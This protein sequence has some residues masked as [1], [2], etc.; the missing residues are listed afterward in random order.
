MEWRGTVEAGPGDRGRKLRYEGDPGMWVPALLYEP[1]A[2]RGRVPAV[3]NPN[4]HHPGGKA[5]DYKQARCINLA[6]RGML[7][8]NTEFIGMGELRA[9]AEH[10]R[11]ALLDLCGVAGI[12]VFYLLMKRGLDV[13]LDHRHADPERVAMTGLSG[14]GWQTALLSALDER[15]KVIVPVAGHSA[16]WQRRGC[17]QDIGDLE[18]CPGDMC[19]IADY[20]V[21]TAMFAPRPSLLIHSA[22]D[23]IFRPEFMRPCLYTPA[24]KVYKRL[25]VEDRIGFYANEDPG[26]HNYD[27]D[28]REQLYKFLKNAWD[29]DISVEDIPCD[30]ELLSEWELN[31]DALEIVRPGSPDLYPTVSCEA[32]L[33]PI[34]QGITPCCGLSWVWASLNSFTPERG[35]CVR[36]RPAWSAC[37]S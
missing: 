6:K 26:T 5:M 9:D 31:V 20:D 27:K 13:L 24:R 7:A 25:G 19:T 14:G 11:I 21:L 36:T 32:V 30:D 34:W 12:G 37:P 8:L 18:Q 17:P 35:E 3:L 15:V 2:L 28:N 10:L 23:S 29:L 33:L 22:N 1:A 16:M 4:G